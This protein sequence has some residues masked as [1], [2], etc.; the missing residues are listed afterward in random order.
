MPKLPTPVLEPNQKL[1]SKTTGKTVRELRTVKGMSQKELAG[2]IGI[3]TSYMCE[4]EK[5]TRNWD[6]ARWNAACE[7]IGKFKKNGK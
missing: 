3:S 4:L 7:A 5:G 2:A 6:L 1:E